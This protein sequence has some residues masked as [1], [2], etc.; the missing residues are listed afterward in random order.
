MQWVYTFTAPDPSPVSSGFPSDSSSGIPRIEVCTQNTYIASNSTLYTRRRRAG[1]SVPFRYNRVGC[2]FR[3]LIKKA[4]RRN[5]G[6][7]S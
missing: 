6:E 7:W 4:G 5:A 3:E 2:I 1:W